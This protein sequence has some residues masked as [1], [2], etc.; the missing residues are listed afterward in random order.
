MLLKVTDTGT[1]IPPEVVQRMFEP[2]FTTKEI[3]K[4]TGLGLS[5]VMT[6]IKN[7][8]GIID[9][10][11]TVGKGTTFLV[12]LPVAVTTESASTVEGITKLTW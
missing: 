2:F 5:T 9:V 8:G 4:G 12:Y 3:G 1:G 11:T 10:E 7:H 6:I